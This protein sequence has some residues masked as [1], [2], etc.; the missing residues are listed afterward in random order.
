MEVEKLHTISFE[1]IVK[2]IFY[3]R[4]N[5]ILNYNISSGTL[6]IFV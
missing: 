2:T 3:F 5:K 1:N 6:F 4:K